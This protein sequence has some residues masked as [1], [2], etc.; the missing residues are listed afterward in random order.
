MFGYSLI[1]THTHQAMTPAGYL[2]FPAETKKR[3]LEHCN[4]YTKPDLGTVLWFGMLIGLYF[5]LKKC[6]C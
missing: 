6:F 4:C 3:L 2:S 5:K 1:P